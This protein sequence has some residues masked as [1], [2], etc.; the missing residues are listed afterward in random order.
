MVISEKGSAFVLRPTMTEKLRR[1]NKLKS[2]NGEKFWVERCH[3]LFEGGCAR[4]W[5]LE[6]GWT[7][8]VAS[9]WASDDHDQ[10]L[11]VSDK[12]AQYLPTPDSE[13]SYQ[14]LRQHCGTS[15]LLPA[16]FAA[17]SRDPVC[18]PT[19]ADRRS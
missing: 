15:R 14:V 3:F 7:P 8:G 19:A 6:G 17:G 13:V 4:L 2:R 9:P 16:G 5:V 11:Q 12:Q 10:I 1:R 18:F